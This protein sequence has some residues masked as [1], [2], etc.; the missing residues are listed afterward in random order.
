M[1]GLSLFVKVKMYETPF[2]PLRRAL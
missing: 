1:M 2:E